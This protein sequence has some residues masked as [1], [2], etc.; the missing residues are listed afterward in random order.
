MCISAVN[1]TSMKTSM[2][3]VLGEDQKNCHIPTESKPRAS[4]TFPDMILVCF[5]RNEKLAY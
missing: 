3:S 4:K 5:I 1:C 2:V